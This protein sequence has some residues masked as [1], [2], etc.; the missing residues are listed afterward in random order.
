[1]K[2]KTN[3]WWLVGATHAVS[4]RVFVHLFWK[5]NETAHPHMWLTSDLRVQAT[6]LIR[7]SSIF[8]N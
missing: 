4:G 7:H 3:I 8:F 2:Q 5:V 6:R 1:M